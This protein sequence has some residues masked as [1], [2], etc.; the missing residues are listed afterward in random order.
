MVR[1]LEG[2]HR[3]GRE[4][5]LY[6]PVIQFVCQGHHPQLAQSFLCSALHVQ[7]SRAGAGW[8]KYRAG[9]PIL[10]VTLQRHDSLLCHKPSQSE[11]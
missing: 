10:T 5:S 1:A 3:E 11:V 9:V 2:V 8:V 6:S 7:L 4:A